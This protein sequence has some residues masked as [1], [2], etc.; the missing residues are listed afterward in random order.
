MVS[1]TPTAHPPPPPRRAAHRADRA[2]AE[3]QKADHAPTEPSS[4]GTVLAT[5][6]KADCA[7]G[8]I[9][10]SYPSAAVIGALRASDDGQ[11]YGGCKQ[12]LPRP[13]CGRA[14]QVLKVRGRAPQRG[15]S[16]K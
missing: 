1:G 2:A 6:L 10:G 12:A 11:E 16:G 7:D 9:D 13:R 3:P 8:A 4:S 5:E 15:L 14:A